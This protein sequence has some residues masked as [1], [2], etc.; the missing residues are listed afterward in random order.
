MLTPTPFAAAPPASPYA[1]VF[2]DFEN[3]YYF[4]KNHYLDPQDPHDYALDLVRALRDSLKREQ[5][6][7]SLVLNAY[8]DFD[9]IPTGPQGP[10]Y[11]MGVSTRNVLG[12]DHKNAADMQLCIDALEVLYTRPAIGTFVLVAGDRDYIPVLQHLRRQAR[13]VKVVGFRESVSGDLLQMLGQEHFIDARQL[14]PA[15]RLQA[16]EDHRTARLR[17]G[18]DLRRLREQGMVGVQSA[19][20]RQAAQDA[21]ASGSDLPAEDLPSPVAPAPRATPAARPNLLDQLLQEPPATFAPIRRITRDDERRCLEFL[22]E[23]VQ[24]FGGQQGVPEIWASPFLRR[25]TDVLPELPD[26]ERR[27]LLSQLRDAGA[28]RLEKREGEPHPFSVILV[29]YQH[30]DV[31]E[32]NPGPLEEK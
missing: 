1:A 10:L 24:K 21:A 20:A 2:I 7:D 12:T 6:L 3:V 5:G 30:P 29:N 31:R 15:E 19:A 4:L 25:L 26:W 32:L 23:Q 9:K 14:L 27:Q 16:L 28:V 8:A 22:L 13:Q 18:Q 11:L 17:L